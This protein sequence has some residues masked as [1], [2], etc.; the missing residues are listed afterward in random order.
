[1]KKYCLIVNNVITEIIPEFDAIF[2][3]I[4]IEER[5]SREFLDDCI[6]VN[7]DVEVEVGDVYSDGSFTKQPPIEII[8]PIEPELTPG[9]PTLEERISLQIAQNTTE[10]LELSSA[11]NEQ[12]KLEQAQSNAEM[13]ELIMSLQGGV[14]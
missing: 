6:E 10:T 3:D 2:P 4:P 5:Y 12:Q 13:I 9:Q 1:M 7:E 11:L 8:P 14:E